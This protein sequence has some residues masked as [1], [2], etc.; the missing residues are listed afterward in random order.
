MISSILV[1][2]AL[3]ALFANNPRAE[4]FPFDRKTIFLSPVVTATG[5]LSLAEI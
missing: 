5:Q 2:V 3:D 4:I 1:C